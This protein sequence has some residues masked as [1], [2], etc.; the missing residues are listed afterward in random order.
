MSRGGAAVA[1]ALGLGVAVL[2]GCTSR[3]ARGAWTP[4]PVGWSGQHPGAVP[5][6]P[7]AGGAAAPW[8]A[9]PV[10]ET[11][12]P[13]WSAAPVSPTPSPAGGAFLV[14]LDLRGPG[15]AARLPDAHASLARLGGVMR[16]PPLWEVAPQPGGGLG[17]LAAVL[18]RELCA[19]DL[20]IVYR[21]RPAGMER[22]EFAGH[23]ACRAEATPPSAAPPIPGAAPPPP[24]GSA[25][26]PPR[27]D[28]F[29]DRF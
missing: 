23:R 5:G 8:G 26:P 4:A 7:A 15:G 10:G 25:S 21:A 12:D 1:L 6:A 16:T 17:S 22:S 27:R 14:V 3:P 19:E 11:R 13:W 2:G 9:G 29:Y 18:E 24:P 20:V 28:P